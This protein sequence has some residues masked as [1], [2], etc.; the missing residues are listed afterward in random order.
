MTNRAPVP[1][2][3]TAELSRVHSRKTNGQASSASSASWAL[4]QGAPQFRRTE[5]IAAFVDGQHL[6]QRELPTSVT[7]SHAKSVA[8]NQ[9]GTSCPTP[10]CE[11][12]ASIEALIS[13]PLFHYSRPRGRPP[14]F[15]HESAVK[16]GRR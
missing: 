11:I 4:R 13:E 1:N 2:C 5:P 7:L 8:L 10:S 3:R 6:E 16:T 15:A 14:E 9:G 12:E